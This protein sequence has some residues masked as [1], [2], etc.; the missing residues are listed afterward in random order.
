MFSRDW[1]GHAALRIASRVERQDNPDLSTH[2]PGPLDRCPGQLGPPDMGALHP[3]RNIYEAAG[4]WLWVVLSVKTSQFL[5]ELKL[6]TTDL[7]AGF[8]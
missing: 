1:A 2:L 5:Q 3:G 4:R 8:Q 7:P 6:I